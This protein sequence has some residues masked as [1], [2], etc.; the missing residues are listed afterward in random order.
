MQTKNISKE[1]T[2]KM[3]SEVGISAIE[4]T[5]VKNFIESIIPDF[6]VKLSEINKNLAKNDVQPE[7]NK[8][9]QEMI[10]NISQLQSRIKSRRL[11]S[12][13]KQYFR[14]KVGFSAYES[15]LVRRAFEKPLGYPG[16]YELLEAIYGNKPI[17]GGIGKYWD[18]YFLAD[19][20]A[21]AVRGRKDETVKFLKKEIENTQLP[22][23]IL[24]LA[25]G[26]SRD[27]NELLELISP[28]QKNSITITCVDQ[29]KRA[30]MFSQNALSEYGANV[31][32]VE[33]NII[34][35]SENKHN[36]QHIIYSIG[37]TDYFPDRVL[38]KFLKTCY[39]LLEDNGKL[40]ISHKDRLVYD[41]IVE[42]WFCD[43]TFY[44]RTEKELLKIVS[45]FVG[46]QSKIT[47]FRGDSKI[48]YFFIIRK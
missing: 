46:D 16:D 19:P 26:S 27:V 12:K 1:D 47:A 23:R 24:N 39:D 14:G 20:L 38:R 18:A 44:P 17:S 32:F 8:C 35:L 36:K 2:I 33:E 41:P 30:L 43:W 29:D 22:I 34:N 25:C 3:I 28:H 7:L 21:E 37:L 15:W 9:V 13:I 11:L 48:I 31:S 5:F 6:E 45:S 4:Q 42:D 40:F 10:K